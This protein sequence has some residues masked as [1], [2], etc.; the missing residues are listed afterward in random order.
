MIRVRIENHLNNNNILPKNQHGSRNGHSTITAVQEIEKAIKQNKTKGKTSVILS[1]DLTNAFDTIDHGLLLQKFEHIGVRGKPYFLIQSYLDQRNAYVEVQ[2]YSSDLR[3]CRPYSVIQGGKLSG[4]FFSVYTLETTKLD[5]IMKNNDE[6]KFISGE[7][8]TESNK[9]ELQS[10][11]YVDDVNHVAGNANI[12]DL[13]EFTGKL[14]NAVTEIYKENLL[15]M[16]V[17]KTQLLQIESST[18]ECLNSSRRMVSIISQQGNITTAKTDMKI[19]GVTLNCRASLDTN[20]S[21]MKSRIGLELN[22]LKP[23]LSSLRPVDRKI[24]LN[25]KLTSIL[26]YALPLYLGETEA[27]MNRFEAAYMSIYRRIRGGYTFRVN[28][29]TI[30]KDINTD[31]PRMHIAKKA[32]TFI[33]KQLSHRSCHS[34]VDRL[35]I[36]KRIASMIHM[37]NP[38]NGIYPTSLDRGV[39]LY[40]KL[41]TDLKSKRIGPFKRHLKK[42]DIKTH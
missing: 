20:T 14:L 38:Q 28:R 24:I 23:Y 36:P 27:T 17:T 3:R 19:L 7:T 6:L 22:K 35:I 10:T 1:T 29:K 30:C 9:T 15:S 13:E 32:V 33:H 18:N 26:D 12:E 37:R 11:G 31:L 42:N 41:S 2:G 4:Q 5:E 40:N 25:C 21:R 8:L 39:S 16:N 34:L